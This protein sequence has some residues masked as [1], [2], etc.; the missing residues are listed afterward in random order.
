MTTVLLVALTKLIFICVRK[1]ISS[2]SERDINRANKK[3]QWSDK[4]LS[5]RPFEKSFEHCLSVSECLMDIQIT[6]KVINVVII[7]Q[8]LWDFYLD[9]V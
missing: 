5:V 6:K 7:T 4:F 2:K 1:C 9:L 8:F 3:R